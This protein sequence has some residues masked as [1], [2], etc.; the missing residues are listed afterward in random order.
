MTN[1][2]VPK[3]KKIAKKVVKT[4]KISTKNKVVKVSKKVLKKVSK[5]P[6]SKVAPR[7]GVIKLKKSP[8]NPII[9]P[10]LYPWESK[11]TFNPSAFLAKS[12]VHLIYRAIG[13]D[14]SSVLGYA[15]SDDG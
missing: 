2:A 4:K 14:D 5:K 8:Q 7:R 6:Q 10:R 15:G 1:M 12:K 9:E 11:A 13:D 3:K